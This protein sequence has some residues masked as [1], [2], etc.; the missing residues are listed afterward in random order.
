[1]FLPS[2]R[3]REYRRYLR[4]RRRRRALSLAIMLALVGLIAALL[5][6]HAHNRSDGHTRDHAPRPSRAASPAHGSPLTANS[7]SPAT[8]GQDLSW[9][10]FHGIE[11]P[12][13]AHDGPR[14]TSG[15]LASGFTDTPRGAL[16]AAIDIGVRTA[17]LWGPPI[18]TPTIDRQVTG[19]DAAALL[20]ADTSSYNALRAASH[21]P[22]GQP[23]GRGYAVEAAYRFDTWTPAD[24]TVDVVTEGPGSGGATVLAATRIEVVWQHGDWRLV[25]PPGGDWASSAT[26]ISSLTGYTAFPNEG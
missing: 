4:Y 7:S 17:A 15:G 24:A 8:A 6:A 12:V 22:A 1:V 25:A 13:S 21:V 16:L 11:L 3:Y 18:Y 20:H 23:A 10:D 19:P 2:P 26:S 9:T 5:H 14:D